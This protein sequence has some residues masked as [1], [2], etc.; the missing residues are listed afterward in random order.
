LHKTA[1]LIVAK[2]KAEESDRLKMAFL[3]NISHEFRTPMNGILGFSNLITDDHLTKEE[4]LNCA[5]YIKKSCT[6]LLNIVND[7]VEISKVHSELIQVD[8][9]VV[10]LNNILQELIAEYENSIREKNIDFEFVIDLKDENK[11]I[12][13]D[14]KKIRRVLWHLMGNAIKFTFQGYVKLSVI[15]SSNDMLEITVKDNG[16][17]I[18]DE[19]Q[20]IIFEPFRQAEVELSKSHGGTGVGLSLTKAYVE[21][22]GGSIELKSK[23]GEGT[24]ISIRIPYIIE[25]FEVK[26]IEKIHTPNLNNKTLLIAEDDEMNFIL[27]KQ[28]LTK[29]NIN[30]IHAWNGEEAVNLFKDNPQI[31]LVLMDIR[32]PVMNGYDATKAIKNIKPEIPVIAHTAHVSKVGSKDKIFNIFDGLIAKPLI[33]DTFIDTI[34]KAL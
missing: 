20:K 26:K 15:Q 28:L 22:M 34:K 7:T 5:N 18:P 6:Q 29:L 25:E 2:N 19:L 16:I 14:E 27:V 12:K 32:M 17:G 8:N 30:V 23:S 3:N 9:S 10:N 31:N 1:D 21:I 4:R 24:T 13:T 11:L 33:R